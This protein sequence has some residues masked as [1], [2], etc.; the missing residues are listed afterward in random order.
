VSDVE[1]TESP[2]EAAAGTVG[3]DAIDAF[4]LLGH[5]TRLAI[6]LAIWEDHDLEADD[7][8]VAFSRIFERVGHDDPGN[9][10]YHLEKLEGQFVRQR[11][12]RGGYELRV[13]AQKLVRAVIAGAG[14]HDERREPTEIDQS[15]PF[16]GAPTVM[17]YRE[18]ILFW[19]CHEC[20][21]M[22]P[23]QDFASFDPPGPLTAHPFD[24]AGLREWTPEELW[25]ASLV[26]GWRRLRSMFDGACPSCSSPVDRWFDWCPDHDRTGVTTAGCDSGRRLASGVSPAITSVARH[27]NASHCFTRPSFPSTTTTASRPESGLTTPSTRNESTTS[28]STTKWRSLTRTRSG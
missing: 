27:R 15:C 24:P 9:L 25:A 14:V 21:G 8:A 12:D 19:A 22:T 3:Q 16:C 26:V 17:S 10:R 2:L 6:L 7:N 20:G 5:E 11:T 18:G 23:G 1:S 28:C 4:A 13:P